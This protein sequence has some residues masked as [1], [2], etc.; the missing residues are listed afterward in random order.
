MPPRTFFQPCS[1]VFNVSALQ[2]P[3]AALS[4]SSCH[5]SSRAASSGAAKKKK[6]RH[7]YAVA[8]AKQRKASNLSRRAVLK[9]ER[10]SSL[11]DPVVGNPTPFTQLLQAKPSD[12]AVPTSEDGYAPTPGV[13]DLNYDISSEDF[14]AAL[15]RSK[16]LTTPVSA[17]ESS[18][19]DPEA[20]AEAARRHEESHVTAQEAISRIMQLNKGNNKDLSRINIQR[21]IHTFG[22]HVT[23]SQLPPKPPACVDPSAPK[24]PP[25]APRAGPDTGSSEVQI[26]VLTSKILVLAKMV[27]KYGHK[28]KHNKRNLRL[29]VHKRQKLLNYL[30]RKE[31]GGPRW[32]NVMDQLGLTTASWK[33]EISI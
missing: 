4:V 10:I 28:D 8:Q 16:D 27:E 24:H 18:L 23:D 19:I 5:V 32:Q 6:S 14:K 26:A 12:S 30:R 17:G 1:R 22:R 25:R 33:G 2:N 3:F 11:G 13:P 20:V 31:R 7:P 9:Q 15:A 29:L 21:C